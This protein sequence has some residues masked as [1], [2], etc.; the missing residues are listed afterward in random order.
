MLALRG[1]GGSRWHH[2][3]CIP[4][5][6]RGGKAVERRQTASVTCAARHEQSGSAVSGCSCV[7]SGGATCKKLMELCSIG[8]PSGASWSPTGASDLLRVLACNAASR[9]DAARHRI[10]DMQPD[11]PVDVCDAPLPRP[12]PQLLGGR[13]SSGVREADDAA[14]AAWMS[15][16]SRCP[17]LNASMG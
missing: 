3:K 14:A 15:S 10:D 2:H 16:K 7:W 17:P 1:P 9:R 6:L 8:V 13:R 4:A 12:E 11:A 5:H